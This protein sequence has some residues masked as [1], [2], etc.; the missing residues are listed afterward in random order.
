ME[1]SESKAMA[2]EP[3]QDEDLCMVCTEKLEFVSI[4]ECNH[5]FCC[6]LCALKLRLLSQDKSCIYCKQAQPQIVIVNAKTTGHKLFQDFRIWGGV[7]GDGKFPRNAAVFVLFL[8]KLQA[9]T[10]R[11]KIIDDGIGLLD[12]VL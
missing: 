4:G 8:L 2:K 9:Y 6:A 12:I 7:I 10:T 5:K 1:E 3:P 11:K